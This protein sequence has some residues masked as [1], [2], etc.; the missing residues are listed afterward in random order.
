MGSNNDELLDFGLKTR[1]V[2]LVEINSPYI[3]GNDTTYVN[4]LFQYFHQNKIDKM[5]NEDAIVVHNDGVNMTPYN[6]NT[7]NSIVQS[8]MQQQGSV[9]APNNLLP[10]ELPHLVVS[11]YLTYGM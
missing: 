10:K 11:N 5:S 4:E 9:N 8:Q 6:D 2:P 7:D 1:M 3:E